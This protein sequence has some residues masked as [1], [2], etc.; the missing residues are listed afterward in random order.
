MWHAHQGHAEGAGSSQPEVE[1]HWWKRGRM[2]KILDSFFYLLSSCFVRK[3]CIFVVLV[4]GS[5]RGGFVVG[6]C[7]EFSSLSRLCVARKTFCWF[8]H[9][10]VVDKRLAS[11]SILFFCLSV[12]WYPT[13]MI[14]DCCT[15]IC[16]SVYLLLFF[17][18]SR[19]ST[20]YRVYHKQQT[21]VG[22]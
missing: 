17:I 18:F 19:F 5:S 11:P 21:Y 3:E 13:C 22:T 2:R 7:L 14:Y 9:G 16:G 15:I 8:L 4:H 1:L 6:R 10:S 12:L 20:L